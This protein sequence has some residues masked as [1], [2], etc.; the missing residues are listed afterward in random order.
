MRE[1]REGRAGGRAGKG[2][3][4]KGKGQ[5]AKGK[6]QR[7]RGKGQGAK[8]KGQR[9]RHASKVTGRQAD[10]VTGIIILFVSV[11]CNACNLRSIRSGKLYSLMMNVIKDESRV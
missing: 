2:Q 8:G 11:R 10:K 1:G 4:A 3:R 7:A 9:G 5:R 6:G